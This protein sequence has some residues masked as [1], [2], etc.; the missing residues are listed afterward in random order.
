[1]KPSTSKTLVLGFPIDYNVSTCTDQS[2]VPCQVQYCESI[3]A[4]SIVI[5]H[6]ALI[7]LM[8][9]E[10]LRV[11]LPKRVIGHK[12]N[13]N[14]WMLINWN[15]IR[16]MSTYCPKGFFMFCCNIPNFS[17]DACHIAVCQL[18]IMGA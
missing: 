16:S 13:H 4:Q 2:P 11:Y 1:M 14:N 10:S 5:N 9:P 7:P 6:L 8:N 17:G 12:N 3:N 15:H 18:M